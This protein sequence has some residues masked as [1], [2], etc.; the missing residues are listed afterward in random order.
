VENDTAKPGERLAEILEA[1]READEIDRD[2]ARRLLRERS[3][4]RRN[5]QLSAMVRALEKDNAHLSE[6]NDRLLHLEAYTPQPFGVRPRTQK[7]IASGK[8][9]CV[10]TALASDWHMEERIRPEAVKGLNEYTPEIAQERARNFFRNFHTL[11]DIQRHGAIID[12]AMLW[13][14]G[15]F[16]TGYIH[17][18]LVEENWLSPVEAIELVFD[19]LVGGMDYLLAEADLESLFVPTNHGNHGRTTDKS[20]IASGARNSYEWALY[21]R[22]AKHYKK[23]AR[24]K[25]QIADGYHNWV[26]LEGVKL[27]FHHGDAVRYHGGVGGLSVPLLKKIAQWDTQPSATGGSA[28]PANYTFN[29]HLHTYLPG[30]VFGSNGS[31]L[32][33]GAFGDFIGAAYEDPQQMFCLVDLDT[34][35][36]RRVIGHFPIRVTR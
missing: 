22:L 30:N 27:R 1:E 16:I 5:R 14:G 6:L 15:D 9:R 28:E 36:T 3:A 4:V 8:N 11:I 13:L 29:G 17:P 23:D 7:E 25:F 10:A 20:R 33:F 34:E 26:E 35:A 2:E 12:T 19:T 24:V 31:L 32:G 21:H 18:E